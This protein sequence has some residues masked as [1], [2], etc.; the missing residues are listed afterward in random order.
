MLSAARYSGSLLT[1]GG[2]TLLLFLLG[3]LYPS[4]A[5]LVREKKGMQISAIIDT[6]RSNHASQCSCISPDR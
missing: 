1:P 3:S 5:R 2:Q 4:N 6:Q